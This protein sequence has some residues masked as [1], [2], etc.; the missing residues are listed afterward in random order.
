MFP[1]LVQYLWIAWLVLAV[2]FVIIELLTLE[3]TFLML[4]SGTL[5]GGLGVNLLGGTWWLQVLAAAAVSALLLFTIRPLLLR[6]LHRSSQHIPTNV[7]ALTGMSARVVGAFTDGDGSVKLDNGETWTARLADASASVAPG[8][9]VTVTAV[10]GA[11][12]VVAP[13]E[14]TPA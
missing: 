13:E 2:L 6:A 4:A 7:D 5:I 12:V 9:R 10:R 8:Q 3:F 14:G 1:D 11:T